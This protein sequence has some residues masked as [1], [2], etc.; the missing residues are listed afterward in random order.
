MTRKERAMELF[1]QGYNCA[2]AVTLAFADLLPVD[3]AT[4]SRMACSFGG[5][6]GR[7]REV[8][9]AASGM[10]M[11]YGLVRGYDGPEK[12]EVKAKHYA[13]VQAMA[14]AFEAANG[15]LVCRELLGLA[16][17]HDAPE[18]S[19]RTHE[20]YQ[21]RPCRDIV[22]AAAEILEEYLTGEGKA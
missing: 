22:G 16:E 3:E 19:E 1:G 15:A 7:L 21:K 5:G 18:P 2:Q 13:A 17:K 4:A 6:M 20:F 10:F 11:V 12:G 8:C 14:K 9:G